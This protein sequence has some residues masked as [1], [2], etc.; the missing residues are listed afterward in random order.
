MKILYLDCFSGAS[1]DML[2]GALLDLG[3]SAERLINELNKLNLSGYKIEINKVNKYAI[4]GT[5]VNITVEDDGYENGHDHDVAHD[6]RHDHMHDA[7]HDHPHDHIHPHAHDHPHEHSHPHER[8]LKDILQIIDGSGVAERA[9]DMSRRVFTVIAA[10]EGKVHGVPA[11]DVVF[12][13]IGALD[14]IID[15]VG[16]C[17]CVDLLEIDEIRA[18]ELHEGRGFVNTRH[19]RLPVPVPAVLEIL[20]GSGIPI[21]TEDIGCELLTPTGAGFIRALSKS[22]GPM[23]AMSVARAGYGFGKRDTG[24]LNALRAVLGE[25]APNHKSKNGETAHCGGQAADKTVPTDALN[26]GATGVASVETGVAVDSSSDTVVLLEAN[27]DDMPAEALGYAMERLLNA[28]ALDVYFTPIYMKKNRP[29][30]I[31]TAISSPEK[32]D[33]LTDV[34]F[35]ETTT[36]GVRASIHTR[37]TMRRNSKTVVIG[38]QGT[39]GAQGET[40]EQDATGAKGEIGERAEIRIKTA[41]RKGVARFSPE[42]EDCRD[43]ALRTGLPFL[44]VYNIARDAYSRASNDKQSLANAQKRKE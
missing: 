11:E 10:A 13:E 38:V 6:H 28:G 26:S 43:Y 27:I 15:I 17:I 39:A 25:T 14:S 36:L 19:G 18:S 12:H 1:G 2:L 9:K 35:S 22:Y 32:R 16:A 44:D 31:L 21:V 42:Y 30:V 24:R 37:E 34:I 7:G 5:D 40:G 20:S 8:S 29:A 33:A 23:P 4:T 41:E 3:V